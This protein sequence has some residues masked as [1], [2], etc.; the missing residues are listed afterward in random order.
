VAF[1]PELWK[2]YNAKLHRAGETFWRVMVRRA[3]EERIRLSQ[4]VKYDPQA[5]SK[6]R[7]PWYR[8]QIESEID[9]WNA[10]DGVGSQQG[11]SLG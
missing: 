2:V 8:E 11:C 5:E 10:Q 1:L 4:S 7:G 9:N 3:T 6:V